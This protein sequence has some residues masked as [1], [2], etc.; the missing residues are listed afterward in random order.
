MYTSLDHFVQA[1]LTGNSDIVGV[2]GRVETHPNVALLDG[3]IV[4]LAR[5]DLA[6]QPGQST[7]ISQVAL[8]M[9]QV[10]FEALLIRITKQDTQLVERRNPADDTVRLVPLLD[11]KLSEVRTVLAC[12]ACDEGYFLWVLFRHSLLTKS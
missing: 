11:Q 2:F 10:V 1:Q 6:Y 4:R 3:H 5:L 9:A 12:D 8:V 7:D